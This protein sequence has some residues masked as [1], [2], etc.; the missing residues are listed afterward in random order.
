M[1]RLVGPP[2]IRCEAMT[3]D[4][5]Q[6]EPYEVALRWLK[7][8]EGRIRRL[9]DD[10]RVWEKLQAMIAANPALHRPSDF[11]RW[12][13]DMY[14]AG[15]AMA[16]RRLVDEH[17][18]AVSFVRF[19][20]L[21]KENPN[22]VSRARYRRLFE[23]DRHGQFE[24]LQELGEFDNYVDAFY[25]DLV[26]PGVDAPDP[27]DVNTEITTLKKVTKRLAVFATKVIAHADEPKPTN[28]PKFV[29]VGIAIEKF[30]ELLKR[31]VALTRA[32]TISV[33]SVAQY[34]PEAI[35]RVPW[36]PPKTKQEGR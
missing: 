25:D 30:E 6:N 10:Q 24:V 1:Q 36:I 31:Y 27:R 18:K 20:R 11:Y 21:V 23:Q 14:V 28:L 32:A 2:I 26:A 22:I 34:D 5:L 3:D 33:G 7:E 4:V 19:L 15:M 17:D 35:F 16:I 12:L 13:Q 9:R 8:L 29:E